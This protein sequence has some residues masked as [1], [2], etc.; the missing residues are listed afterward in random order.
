MYGKSVWMD[1]KK[2]PRWKGAEEPGRLRDLI[3][4]RWSKACQDYLT[5]IRS[6]GSMTCEGMEMLKLD[7]I[8]KRCFCHAER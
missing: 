1:A 7:I 4:S 3:G 5:P 6:E 8:P 2:E